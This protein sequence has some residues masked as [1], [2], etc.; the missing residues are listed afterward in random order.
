MA[1][2]RDRV[3]NADLRVG[4]AVPDRRH[5]IFDG[6]FERPHIGRR[7]DARP[8]LHR[9]RLGLEIQTI[10]LTLVHAAV[11]VEQRHTLAV[12]RDLDLLVE[13]RVGTHQLADRCGVQRHGKHVLAIGRKVVG[14]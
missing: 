12:H 4:Q 1:L 5:E 9:D 3:L 7:H 8:G 6:P 11:D 14:G 13:G 2:N 10:R